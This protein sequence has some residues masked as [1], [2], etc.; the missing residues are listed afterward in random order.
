MKNMRL[1]LTS[2]FIEDLAAIANGDPRV[3][4]RGKIIVTVDAT[5]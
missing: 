2:E 5:F 1:R 3:Q 4:L